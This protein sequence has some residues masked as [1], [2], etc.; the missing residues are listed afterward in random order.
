MTL[1]EK[2]IS[3]EKLNAINEAYSYMN[4]FLE[5]QEFIA[6]DSLT[7]ADF[8]CVSTVST[9]TI[10]IPISTERFPHLSK[11]YHR[12]K[13]LPYYEEGNGIGLHRLDMLV[14]TKLGKP[15]HNEY[16]S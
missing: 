15:L 9:A 13:S 11:W 14:E 7:I 5:N 4:T 1:D 2:E 6:G 3:N 8:C 10:I 12:C 16:N